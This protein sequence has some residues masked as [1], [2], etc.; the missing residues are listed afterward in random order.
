M[1]RSGLLLTISFSVMACGGLTTTPTGQDKQ[2]DSGGG[3]ISQDAGDAKTTAPNTDGGVSPACP[4]ATTDGTCVKCTS[5]S[6]RCGDAIYPTCPASIA[7][8]NPCADAQTTAC[9]TCSGTKGE[10]YLCAFSPNGLV[11]RDDSE[12]VCAPK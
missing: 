6:W 3:T 1:R 9:I 5:D 2:D 4:P 7:A 8:G 12:L 10:R 11:W